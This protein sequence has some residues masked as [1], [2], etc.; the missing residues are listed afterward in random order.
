MEGLR[1]RWAFKCTLEKVGKSV[2]QSEIE[3]SDGK[4]SEIRFG[5]TRLWWSSA[6]VRQRQPDQD[7]GGVVNGGTAGN[8]ATFA[9]GAAKGEL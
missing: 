6:P 5:G 1:G 4:R 3:F 9:L 7:G 2:F 8:G